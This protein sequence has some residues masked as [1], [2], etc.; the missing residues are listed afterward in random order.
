MDGM[1]MLIV[2]GFDMEHEYTTHKSI[3]SGQVIEFPLYNQTY[4]G[5]V[6]NPGVENT[7][8]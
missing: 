8:A 3:A 2:S 6:P 7:R 5:L 1:N 4:I